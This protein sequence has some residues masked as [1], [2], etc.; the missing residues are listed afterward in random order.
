MIKLTTNRQETLST[1]GTL[2]LEGFKV[3]MACMLGLFVS[4]DCNGEECTMSNKFTETSPENVVVMVC[5]ILTLF[6]FIYA[7][8]IEFTRERYIIHNLNDNDELADDHLVDIIDQKPEIKNKLCIYNKQFYNSTIFAIVSAIIN[9]I[10][11]SIIIIYS[12]YNGIKT[13][14]GIVTN[15]VL[16]SGT[17]Y[18][19]YRISNECIKKGYALSSTRLE[20]ISYNDFEKKHKSEIADETRDVIVDT[21]DVKIE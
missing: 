17:I 18:S 6:I 15:I 9:F 14:T 2:A 8:F 1:I 7:Y 12:H 16:V 4:Q 20:P 3:L 13:L 21:D 10:I 11:S 19:N 5:N